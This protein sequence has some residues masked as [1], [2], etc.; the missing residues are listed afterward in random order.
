[1]TPADQLTSAIQ[2]TPATQ[3]TLAK[4]LMPTIIT[5]I[6]SSSSAIGSSLLTVHPANSDGSM[7]TGSCMF[8][9][10]SLCTLNLASSL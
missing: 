9:H 6:E 3:L 10:G 7:N 1:M 5:D 2:M 8:T 4:Q